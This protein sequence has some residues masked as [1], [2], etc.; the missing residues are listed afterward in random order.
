MF[1]H[2][3]YNK[4]AAL[5]MINDVM[6]LFQDPSSRAWMTTMLSKEQRVRYLAFDPIAK[7]L[8]YCPYLDLT[9]N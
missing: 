6:P 9:N 4:F 8:H 5:E 1:E 7:G 3:A 2:G